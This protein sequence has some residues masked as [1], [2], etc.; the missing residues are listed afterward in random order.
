MPHSTF[1]IDID[2][3]TWDSDWPTK[4][5]DMV[6]ALNIIIRHQAETGGPLRLIDDWRE[7][8]DGTFLVQLSEWL[9]ELNQVFYERY[10]DKAEESM[11][12]VMRELMPMDSVH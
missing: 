9:V 6:T 5:S 7:S 11:Q 1:N 3:L 2:A 4:R 12:R 8:E 10:G